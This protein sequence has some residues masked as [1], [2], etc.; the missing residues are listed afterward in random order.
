VNR[1]EGVGGGRTI[2]VKLGFVARRM[3][4]EHR[5]ALLLLNVV[6]WGSVLAWTSWIAL[7]WV[8]SAAARPASETAAPSHPEIDLGT[9]VAT[10]AAA[11][12]FGKARES[13]TR[14]SAHA[15]KLDIKLKGALAGAGGPTA[16]IVNTGDEDQLVLLGKELKVGVVLEAVHPN[17]VVI[18]RNGVEERVDL[19]EIG[20]DPAHSSGGPQPPHKPHSGWRP[21][22]APPSG[23]ETTAE[24]EAPFS[25]PPPPPVPESQAAPAPLSRI[26][27]AK[28]VDRAKAANTSQWGA[29]DPR[30]PVVPGELNNWASSNWASSIMDGIASIFAGPR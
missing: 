27:R 8:E 2:S 22:M 4:A 18:R 20:T 24:T 25:P 26:W 10:A 17:Y 3:F 16:A 21:P 30:T 5:H 9:A 12:V 15:P 11:P 14:D 1:A 23:G 6:L 29:W 7:P 19:V 28:E 13:E